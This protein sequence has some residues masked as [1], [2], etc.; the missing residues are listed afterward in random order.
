MTLWKG[1][2]VRVREEEEEPK[3]GEMRGEEAITPFIIR[4]WN[5]GTGNCDP[6]R[7]RAGGR[8]GEGR[9]VRE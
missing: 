2:R 3:N 9:Y 7:G 6:S 1:V 5:T 8:A 4:I